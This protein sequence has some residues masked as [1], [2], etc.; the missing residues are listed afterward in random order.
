MRTVEVADDRSLVTARHG[1]RAADAH[2][3]RGQDGV[4]KARGGRPAG[5]FECAGTPAAARLAVELVPPLGRVILAGV[6]LEPLDLAAPP[7][8]RS[9]CSGAGASR[10]TS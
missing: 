10:W 2:S 7:V 1:A 6:A 5:V 3:V 4:L 8:R 9:T